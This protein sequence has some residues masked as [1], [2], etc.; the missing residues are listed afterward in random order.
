MAGGQ[1]PEGGP[2]SSG[3]GASTTSGFGGG[4]SDGG[5]GGSVVCPKCGSPCAHVNAFVSSTRFVKCEN[6]SHF[7]VVLSEAD[8]KAGGSVPG[9]FPSNQQQQQQQH[10]GSFGFRGSPGFQQQGQNL[11]KGSQQQQQQ[12]QQPN[13]QQMQNQAPP[14]APKKIYE[15]LDK[16]IVGQDKAKRA[17]SVAVYNH[18]KRIYHNLPIISKSK[19]AQ[20]VSDQQGNHMHPHHHLHHHHVNPQDLFHNNNNL[21]P[22]PTTPQQPAMPSHR[23][24]MHIA[25]MGSALGVGFYTG[26]GHGQ[27]QQQQDPAGVQQQ[28]SELLEP[29][30][31][32]GKEMA[33]IRLDK[34]NIMMFGSTGSGK[35]LL[36]QTIARCLD[37]P[38]A[39]CDCTTLTM[40]GYVG[41]DIESVVAKLL[42]DANFNVERA[43]TGIIFLDEVDKIGAVSLDQMIYLS[44]DQSINR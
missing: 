29:Q 14:P 10:Q 27:D 18:Y 30:D 7:F 34:S 24:L 15:Y 8:S 25:G 6:C 4:G 31:G 32:D 21:G 2:T 13:Q 12:N 44:N 9:R 42:Q 33:N 16:Y 19:D 36:A 26:G 43:Q 17:L 37:V 5:T 28:G 22:S 38:F 1:G 41:D 11:R 39:I 35:T 3:N 23:D 40:A 20:K